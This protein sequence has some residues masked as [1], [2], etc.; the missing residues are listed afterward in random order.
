MAF[1]PLINNLMPV[2]QYQGVE[3]KLGATSSHTAS[4]PTLNKI[5]GKKILIVGLGA[6]T[7]GQILTVFEQLT[8]ALVNYEFVNCCVGGQDINDHFIKDSPIWANV[9]SKLKSI[10]RSY[11]DVQ[12]VIMCQD[13][14]KDRSLTFD[15]AYTLKTKIIQLITMLKSVEFFPNL[16]HVELF[17]RYYSEMV[18][19]PQ[20]QSPSDY[21]NGYS[22]KFVVEECISQN[23]RI[24][25]VFVNDLNGYLYTD[26]LLRRSDGFKILLSWFKRNGTSIHLNVAASGD[27]KTAQYIFDNLKNNYPEFR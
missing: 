14:L 12:M 23:N 1:T 9:D 16:Q 25:G 13:D 11:A 8:A 17:S 5:D 2:P 21:H 3:I 7:P 27:D 10:G 22:N 6:S 19:D 4:R 20:F 18:T 24:S 15:A 26:G